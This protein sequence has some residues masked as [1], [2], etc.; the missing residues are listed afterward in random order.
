MEIYIKLYLFKKKI[1][2]EFKIFS[3]LNFHQKSNS[4]H[5][6]FSRINELR[7]FLWG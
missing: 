7:S 1:V 4:N 2:N 6:F 5:I 3:F